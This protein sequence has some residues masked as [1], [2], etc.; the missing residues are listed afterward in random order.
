MSLGVVRAMIRFAALLAITVLAAGCSWFYGFPPGEA[1]P[2]PSTIATYASGRA[3][4]TIDGGGTTIVLDRLTTPGT[5]VDMYGGEVTWRN[6]DGWYMKLLGPTPTGPLGRPGFGSAYLQ[7]DRIADGTHW[8]TSQFG[9]G[10]NVAIMQ[11]DAKG[12]VGSATCRSLRWSDALA[13]GAFDASP[14]SVPGED[15][16][17]AEITFE[18]FP[19]E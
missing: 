4:V 15:P 13:G 8:T 3:T 17:D 19:A 11:A 1:I 10:C 6:D 16:F 12:L 18:A 14:S 2:E 5:L 9:P 7:L